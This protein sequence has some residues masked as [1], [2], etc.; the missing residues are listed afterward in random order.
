VA[1]NPADSYTA[2]AQQGAFAAS[3]HSA[4]FSAKGDVN[5]DDMAMS[6]MGYRKQQQQRHKG[7]VSSSRNGWLHSPPST[8][9]HENFRISTSGRRMPTMVSAEPSDQGSDEANH[10]SG[11]DSNPTDGSNDS[12]GSYS[13]SSRKKPRLEIAEDKSSSLRTMHWGCN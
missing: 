13:D 7:S 5:G 1:S 9:N 6:L 8:E 4:Y 2:F 3:E 11:T 10:S 12:D